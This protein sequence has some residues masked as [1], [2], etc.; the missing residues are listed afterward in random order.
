M[1]ETEEGRQHLNRVQAGRAGNLHDHDDD[2]QALTDVLEARRKHVDDRH[3]DHR[4][5]D[6]RPHER[7]ARDG[8]HANG[9]VTD[10]HD[11]RLDDAEE[12]E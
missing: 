6:R 10:R 5:N 4:N 2:A 1:Q 7:R 3:V 8:L 11:E 12:G 9:Q